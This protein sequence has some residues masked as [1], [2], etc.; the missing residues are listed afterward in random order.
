MNLIFVCWFWT[1]IYLASVPCHDL[2]LCL[3]GGGFHD[4]FYS[5]SF[6]IRQYHDGSGSVARLT[7][8]QIFHC[9]RLLKWS[10]TLRW[11]FHCQQ[12]LLY[13]FY[14]CVS[15]GSLCCTCLHCM[16]RF[17]ETLCPCKYPL[18]LAKILFYTCK[19]RVCSVRVSR[20][21][22]ADWVRPLEASG[23]TAGLCSWHQWRQTR[24]Y[25]TH[26]NTMHVRVVLVDICVRLPPG[27]KNLKLNWKC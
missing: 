18:C 7:R 13:L 25:L 22:V 1:W 5:I 3:A 10:Y 16:K 9:I 15:H 23:H 20:C 26:I 8:G 4:S 14:T 21:P 12:H 19:Y 11:Q 27:F 17:P 2:V 6:K 24:R